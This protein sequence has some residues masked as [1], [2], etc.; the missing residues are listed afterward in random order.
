MNPKRIAFTLL[1][2]ENWTGGY[3][4]LLNLLTLVCRYESKFIQPILFCG[5]DASSKDLE[6]FVALN[7]IEIVRTDV[8]NVDQSRKRLT[9]ALITGVD[10]AALKLF[11]SNSIDVVFESAIYYGWRFPLPAIAWFPDFQHRHMKDKFGLFAYW[12]RDLGF[13][14]QVGSGRLVMLS[15]EDSRKDCEKF[16]PSSIGHTAVVRFTTSVASSSIEENP[17][18]TASDYKLAQP[19]FYLPNQFWQHKNHCIVIDAL[20]NLKQQG[21]EIVVATTGNPHD[22]RDPLLFEK[23]KQCVELFN[24]TNNFIFLGLVP[25]AHVISLMRTCTAMINPSFFEG[26]S[27]TV[28]EARAFNTPMILSDIGV[29][30]EQMGSDADYF[31]PTSSDALARILRRVQLSNVT[32]SIVR[33]ISGQSAERE[34][35]FAHEFA[36]IVGKAA[37]T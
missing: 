25:R 9:K 31:D 21:V 37:T 4:Y 30:R 18:L 32:N 20:H 15:S 16:Y 8:F 35:N 33:N 10:N 34:K 28:E 11:M 29:H 3:N 2:S 17:E 19:F 23:L 24:L 26:W 27:S 1:R 7:L 13:R 36:S 22:P 6:P 12:R 5:N 14:S